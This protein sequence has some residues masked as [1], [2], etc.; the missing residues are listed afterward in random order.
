MDKLPSRRPL[1]PKSAP[2][3][4]LAQKLIPRNLAFDEFEANC[5]QR[6]LVI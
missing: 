3:R 6:R 2:P 1:L 4:H 5:L